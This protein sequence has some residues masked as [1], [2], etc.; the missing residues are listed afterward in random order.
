MYQRLSNPRVR[1][2]GVDVRQLREPKATL[3][4][5]DERIES[6][7]WHAPCRQGLEDLEAHH[8]ADVR[9]LHQGRVS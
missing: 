6:F 1:V 2:L 8:R 5:K 9:V 7:V 3:V 4:D